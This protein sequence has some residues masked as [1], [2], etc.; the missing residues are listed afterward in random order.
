MSSSSL[1]VLS[2]TMSAYWVNA[3]SIKTLTL[4]KTLPLGEA[5]KNGHWGAKTQKDLQLLK[6]FSQIVVSNWRAHKIPLWWSFVVTT[7]GQ[8]KWDGK[9]CNADRGTP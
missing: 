8:S 9:C 6:L 7:H 2:T 3:M 4:K 1:F 5:Q